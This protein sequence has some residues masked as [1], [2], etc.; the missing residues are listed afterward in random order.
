M[1]VVQLALCGANSIT[2]DSRHFD[3][4]AER[5]LFEDVAGVSGKRCIKHGSSVSNEVTTRT[6]SRHFDSPAERRLFED[7]AGVSGNRC[8]KHGSSS[9]V[10][11]W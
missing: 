8:I 2:A 1:R 3:S 9:K 7:V 5:R 4:L 6:N 10:A 11:D